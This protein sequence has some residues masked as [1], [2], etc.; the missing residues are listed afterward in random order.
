MQV[1]YKNVICVSAQHDSCIMQC[2]NPLPPN[3]MLTCRINS[4]PPTSYFS[5]PSTLRLGVRGSQ[6]MSFLSSLRLQLHFLLA[7]YIPGTVCK[8]AFLTTQ[9]R[10]SLCKKPCVPAELVRTCYRTRWQCHTTRRTRKFQKKKKKV[11]FF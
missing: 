11:F 5:I 8:V 7:K 1:K 6:I 10:A 3:A 4:V 9:P 2:Y